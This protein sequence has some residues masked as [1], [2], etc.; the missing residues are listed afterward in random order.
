MN[1][2]GYPS[3]RISLPTSC[4]PFFFVTM[5]FRSIRSFNSLTWEMIP[6]IR[7]PSASPSRAFSAWLK[8][9]SSKEP[10]HSSTNMLSRRIPPAQDWISS[11]SPRARDRAAWK[12]SPPESVLTLR[13]VPL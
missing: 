7:S 9:A 13:S 11:E 2:E 3:N 4:P 1:R 5:I 10:N 12:D 8:A 6:T